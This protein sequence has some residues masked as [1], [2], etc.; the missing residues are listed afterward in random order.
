MQYSV[1]RV[2]T[3]QTCPR[4]YRYRYV[5]RLKTYEDYS[6]PANALYIG[7]AL[8]TGLEKSVE[9]AIREYYGFY[10]VINNR[11][12]E[13][14]MKLEVL[15]PKAKAL[16]PQGRNEV[17]MTSE[18][19]IGFIDLLVDKGDGH[20]DIWDFK[21]SNNVD[22]YLASF[23]LH[24]YKKQFERAV[25]GATVDN[26]YYLIVPKTAIRQKKTEDLSKFR[27]RLEETLQGME[28]KVVKVDYDE[29]RVKEYERTV[30]F[31][32]NEVLYDT[33]PCR[34]CD[35]C[36]FKGLCMDG[37]DLDIDWDNSGYG[38]LKEYEEATHGRA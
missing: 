27:K 12:V 31:I 22:K 16:I 24:V 13:E 14:A 35:W 32:E 23:Q 7:T 6:D 10:P 9:D 37:D 34:L 30:E 26:L 3:Y 11:H 18:T 15:I 2:Q 38:S 8:H 36:E 29:N 20:Y 25:S 5:D 17:R 19:F 28:P 4:Q 1:S 21:Y 33:T